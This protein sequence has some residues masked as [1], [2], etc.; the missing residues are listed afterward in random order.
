MARTNVRTITVAISR[1]TGGPKILGWRFIRCHIERRLD[2]MAKNRQREYDRLTRIY[3]KRYHLPARV[4]KAQQQTES[5]FNPDAVSSAGAFG[6]TQF[7]PGTAPG[8]GVQRGHSH[9]QVAT[10]IRGQA[11]YLAELGGRKNLAGALASYAGGPGNPQ[12]SYAKL[13]LGRSG[14]YKGIDKGKAP[15]AKGGRSYSSKTVTTRT[16]GVDN[17]DARQ[18]LKAAYLANRHDPNALLALAQGLGGAKDVPGTTST[19]TVRTKGSGGRTAAPVGKDGIP[20][21]KPASGVGN[22]EGHKV[23]KWIVPYL[24]YG[25]KHGWKGQVTSGYRSFADQT[26][27]YNSGVRPAARP[28]TSNHEGA[29]FPRGAVDVSDAETLSRILRRR[30]TKK[31][32]FAGAKDPVHFSHP[33]GG[34][35]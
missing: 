4:L 2:L 23:A 16:P 7:M 30:G 26:R 29:D 18:Q 12:A 19:R 11:K 9:H 35:Y 33:H 13:V 8:Y 32:Q 22:F 31:L 21:G 17:S 3:A 10:Q 5:N 15:K 14:K 25:R 28:G 6:L 24:K 20:R 34:S 27:I 1:T